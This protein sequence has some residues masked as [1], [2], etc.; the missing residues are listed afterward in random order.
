MRTVRS[1][2][3]RRGV[4]AYCMVLNICGWDG[5]QAVQ[6]YVLDY[7]EQEM[8]RRTSILDNAMTSA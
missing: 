7:V 8:Q 5:I 6:K 2:A 3:N 1:P 4:S